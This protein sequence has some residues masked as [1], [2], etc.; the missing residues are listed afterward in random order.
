MCGNQLNLRTPRHLQVVNV[1]RF[2]YFFFSP[3][4]V[5]QSER[6]TPNTSQSFFLESLN[7]KSGDK[8]TEHGIIQK[9]GAEGK[10]YA[11][12]KVNIKQKYILISAQ[13]LFYSAAALIEKLPTINL[14]KTNK[15]R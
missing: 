15:Q 10:K 2:L 3:S 9:T 7:S 6:K 11:G 5:L 13:E 12:R 8:K 1:N 4:E 14:T